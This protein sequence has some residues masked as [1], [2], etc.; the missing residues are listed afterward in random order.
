MNDTVVFDTPEKIAFFQLAQCKARLALELHGMKGKGPTAYSNARQWY[1]L[2]GTR[3]SVYEQ[4][5]SM[6]KEA[7]SAAQNGGQ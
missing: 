4:L 6:V 7:I 2:K 3:A 1:D 5:C